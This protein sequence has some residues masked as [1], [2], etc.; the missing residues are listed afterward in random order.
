MVKFSTTINDTTE[1]WTDEKQNN[2]N[3]WFLL[4]IPVEFSSSGQ[5]KKININK[6]IEDI[7]F[8]TYIHT[9]IRRK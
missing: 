8:R 3:K 4:K 6:A 5:L 7:S 1:H 9:L 2:T